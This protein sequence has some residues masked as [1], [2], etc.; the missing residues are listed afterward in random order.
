MTNCRITPFFI[1]LI[2]VAAASAHGQDDRQRTSIGAQYANN[3]APEEA[4]VIHLD[5]PGGHTWHLKNDSNRLDYIPLEDLADVQLL[6][7]DLGTSR[8][9]TS[10]KMCD[11]FRVAWYGRICLIRQKTC[12][13]QWESTEAIWINPNRQPTAHAYV[14]CTPDNVDE[15]HHFDYT[16][17]RC[18]PDETSDCIKPAITKTTPSAQRKKTV[19]PQKQ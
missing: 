2:M 7:S 3:N 17:H 5:I 16:H 8:C 1:L 13:W 9:R 18:R 11:H 19:T 10:S 15:K 4:R 12:P 6:V 14:D